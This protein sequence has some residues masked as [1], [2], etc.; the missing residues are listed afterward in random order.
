[1]STSANSGSDKAP[2]PKVSFIFDGQ[3][4]LPISDNFHQFSGFVQDYVNAMQPGTTPEHARIPVPPSDQFNID[5]V[6]TVMRFVD[7]IAQNAPEWLENPT[8]AS[9]LVDETLSWA[10]AFFKRLDRNDLFGAINAAQYLCVEAF[11]SNACAF[12]GRH[13]NGMTVPEKRDYLGIEPDFSQDEWES[14]LRMPF[15]REIIE[16]QHI[17]NAPSQESRN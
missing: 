12:V 3:T 7:E 6:R 5:D 13:I 9:E 14:F 16:M 15:Y 10:S 2:P 4:E 1:M 11:S 17:S 8:I